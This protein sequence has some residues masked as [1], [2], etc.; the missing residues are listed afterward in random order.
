M[1]NQ[2]LVL[3]HVLTGLL[4][5]PL[6]AQDPIRGPMLGWVWDA[7]QGTIRGILGIAGSSVLGKGI[8][9]EE[10]VK[11]AAISGGQEYALALL[12]DARQLSQIDLRPAVPLK[13]A[14]DA[15]PGAERIVLSPKGNAAV[16]VYK[17]PAKLVVLGGLSASASVL[18][19]IDLTNEGMPAALAISD[20][21]AVVIAAYP[22]AE[23]TIVFFE[24]G[25]RTPLDKTGVVTALAFLENSRDALIGAPDGVFRAPNAGAEPLQLLADTA[26][27]SAI[28]ALDSLRI[29]IVENSN[30]SVIEMNLSSLTRRDA[31]CPCAPTNLTR[32]AG[33]SIFRLNEISSGPLWLV[34]ISDNGLRTIFVPPDPTDPELED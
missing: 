24:S 34:E 19:E 23:K 10:P 6:S 8:E 22:E 12:G 15:P 4:V 30:Q 26:S 3:L 33:S 20:D 9:L 27:A 1:R 31:Q 29:L 32:M 28:A 13:R 21:A 25:D 18:R 17:E 14:I 7:R 11:F 2:K 5:L 16:L